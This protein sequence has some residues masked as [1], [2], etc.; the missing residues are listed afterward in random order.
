MHTK[1]EKSDEEKNAPIEGYDCS[2]VRFQFSPSFQRA[3][4]CHPLRRCVASCLAIALA[5]F[6]VHIT[7]GKDVCAEA[8]LFER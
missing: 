7:C 3:R 1:N 2:P 5:A 4:Y 8:E 6:A